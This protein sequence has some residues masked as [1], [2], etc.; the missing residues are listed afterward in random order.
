MLCH[1]QWVTTRAAF[2]A[3]AASSSRKAVAR[4]RVE[5]GFAAVAQGLFESTL[6]DEWYSDIIDNHKSYISN[7]YLAFWIRYVTLA[8]GTAI[9]RKPLKS[10]GKHSEC[11]TRG[12][13]VYHVHWRLCFDEPSPS[14]IFAD[15]FHHPIR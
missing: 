6:F 8:L 13:W 9:L 4:P 11:I 3:A 5:V 7:N 14:M 2:G 1:A 15:C 10:Q 12:V